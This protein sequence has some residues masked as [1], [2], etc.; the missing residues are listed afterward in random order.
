MNKFIF[1][2]FLFLSFCSPRTNNE[3]DVE[4][5][6]AFSGYSKMDIKKEIYTVY[7]FSK[8]PIEIKF[9]LTDEER[10]RI[11]KKYDSLNLNENINEMKI[12]DNCLNHS[13]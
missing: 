7:F 6:I 4:I 13:P 3:D 10:A 11:F 1:S 8:K 5:V 9:Q 12:W 2:I